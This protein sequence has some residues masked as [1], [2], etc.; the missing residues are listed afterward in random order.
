MFPSVIAGIVVVS[1]LSFLARFPRVPALDVSLLTGGV[2]LATF[3]LLDVLLG[4]MGVE[5]YHTRVRGI[6]FD[7]WNFINFFVYVALPM[8]ALVAG[9]AWLAVRRSR[10]RPSLPL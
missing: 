3:F 8:S 7:E 5:I 1:T 9:L 2:L 10:R 4:P 6:F